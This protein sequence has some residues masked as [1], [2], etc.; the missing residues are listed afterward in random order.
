MATVAWE[1]SNFGN[2]EAKDT[3]ITT[4]IGGYFWSKTSDVTI[5][6][7]QIVEDQFSGLMVNYDQTKTFEVEAACNESENSQTYTIT[8]Y[9]PRSEAE[10]NGDSHFYQLYVTPNDPT[11]KSMAE[12]IA[13]NPLIPNWMEIRDWVSN[14]ITYRYDSDVHGTPEYWQLPRETVSMKT[15]DCEDYAILAVSLLRAA[16]WKPND[17]YVVTGTATENGQTIGHAFVKINILG[18]W[19]CWEPQAKNWLIWVLSDF[20]LLQYHIDGTF[21]D[22]YV[23]MS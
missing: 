9:F 2:K 13:T 19:Y 18:I 10:F 11:V 16:G 4:Y 21:N 12:S 1:V 5:Q 17:V 8:P 3:T 15:G 14:Q 22:Q 23:L 20:M 7:D 6:P